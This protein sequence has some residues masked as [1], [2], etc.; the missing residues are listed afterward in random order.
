MKGE[1]KKKK[2]DVYKEKQEENEG[3]GK[4]GEE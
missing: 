4:G 3:V 2:Q 1:G